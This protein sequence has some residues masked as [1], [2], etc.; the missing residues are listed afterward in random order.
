[1][2]IHG[3]ATLPA[4]NMVAGECVVNGRVIEMVPTFERVGEEEGMIVYRGDVANRGKG[5]LVV[6]G[7][8]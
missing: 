4:A 2:T 3:D 5:R 1:L 7:T 8:G 6:R